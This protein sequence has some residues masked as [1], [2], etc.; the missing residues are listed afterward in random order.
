MTTG[1]TTAIIEASEE[2]ID[3]PDS[4]EVPEKHHHLP[5]DLVAAPAYSVDQQRPVVP[6]S[7]LT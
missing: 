1:S 5:H 7:Q 4:L 6:G 2:V 3:D